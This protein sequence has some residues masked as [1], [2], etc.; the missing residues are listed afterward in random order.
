[1]MAQDDFV[2]SVDQDKTLQ[3]VQSDFWSILTTL[4]F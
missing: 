4:S 3:N 2:D 1:M